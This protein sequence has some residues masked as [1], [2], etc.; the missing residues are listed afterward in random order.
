MTWPSSLLQP[1]EMVPLTLPDFVIDDQNRTGLPF[2]LVDV[3]ET[4]KVRGENY[5][6]VQ[7]I[8]LRYIFLALS[9]YRC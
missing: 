5:A 3:K 1:V 6:Q 8:S 9:K 2:G 7:F 4:E